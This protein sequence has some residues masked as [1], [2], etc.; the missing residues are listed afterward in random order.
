MF[1]KEKVK[2]IILIFSCHKH[3]NT[4]LKE[5][6]IP[7]VNDGW[8][9]FTVIGNPFLP[10]EYDTLKT[11]REE[12]KTLFIKCEDSYIHILKK[13]VKAIQIITD[14]YEVEE[15]I[16]RCGDDLIFN[17]DRLNE[18]LNYK[19]KQDYMGTAI[20]KPPTIFKNHETFMVDY[21]E[22]HLEDLENPL[23]GLIHLTLKDIQMLDKV[24]S[25]SYTGGVVTYL[26]KK[27]CSIL[28]DHMMSIDWNI[29][30]E[31]EDYGYPYIIEDIGIGYILTLNNIEPCA[32][33]LYTNDSS[34]F[35]EVVA[36]HTNKY[37]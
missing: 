22:T 30:Q 5:L 8:L 6:I 14:I 21:Y 26:S 16:L 37:K 34:K 9:I 18:F 28:V 13:V 4:R 32:Y 7:N 20:I 23:H 15:G 19:N 2:G 3:M 27:S 36:L 11:T 33:N 12:V 1:K 10:V 24:P 25:C 17:Q 31:H 35:S 29:F